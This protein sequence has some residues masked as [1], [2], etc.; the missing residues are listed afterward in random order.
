MNQYKSSAELKRLSKGQLLGKYKAVILAFLL[1]FSCIIAIYSIYLLT[2]LRLNSS[3]SAV[4]N[5]LINFMIQLFIGIFAVGNAVLYM[6]IACGRPYNSFDVFAGFKQHADKAI[7]IRF[8]LLVIGYL[9]LA[10]YY[11]LS[12]FYQKYPSGGL[13]LA[14]C[15][16]LI[17]GYGLSVYVD[18]MYCQWAYIILDY[19]D[20]SVRETLRFSRECMRGNKGRRF[21]LSLSFL[22]LW[23]LS[24]LALIGL[25]AFLPFSLVVAFI[26]V[27]FLFPYM[28]ATHTNFYLDIMQQQNAENSTVGTYFDETIE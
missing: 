18:L 4:F 7:S 26:P 20:Y 23:L 13:F 14:A 28:S 5:W 3:I 17:I 11:I 19:P 27:M 10:P 25:V 24:S 15:L 21:Y 9:L 1:Y 22:P 6:N 16:A 2:T 8:V 12:L